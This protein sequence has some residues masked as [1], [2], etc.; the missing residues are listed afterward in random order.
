MI[1]GTRN[2]GSKTI[3]A[4]DVGTNSIHM[5]I[6]AVN[7]HSTLHVLERNKEVVRLGSS[8]TDM[9]QLSAEA[10]DRGVAALQRFAVE[11]GSHKALIKAVATSA[12]REA[13]NR[14]VFLDRV[15]KTSGIDVEVVSGVEEGRLIYVGVLHSLPVISRQTLVIDIGGGSTETVIGSQGD[16]V[17]VHSVKLGHIR[18]T[19]RF[20]PD[21]IATPETIEACRNAVRNEWTPTFQ[22]L[23][24]AGFN[25][26]VGT[27]GTIKALVGMT[28]AR[29]GKHVPESLN[30]VR[31]SRDDMMTTIN[32]VISASADST[33]ALLP[34]LDPKR[35]D[36][37]LA[38][39]LILEQAFVGLNIADLVVSRFAL[40]EGLAFDTAQK[41]HDIQQYHHL[42]SLR[43]QSIMHL[44]ELYQVRLDHA[45]HVKILALQIFDALQNVHNLTDRERELLEAASLLHDV[46]YHI[47]AEQHHKHSEYII[48]NSDLSGFTND[49]ADLIAAIARY[50]RKSHPKKKHPNYNR[51]PAS[52]KRIVR[53]L[54]SI[55][56]I[57]EG[58]DRRQ[59]AIVRNVRAVVTVSTIEL[60]LE[61][62]EKSD[63]EVWSAERRKGL[64]E[65]VFKREVLL[66]PC[67]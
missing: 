47:S 2:S 64:M 51:L 55:L 3:A 59:L 45:E 40:C 6:A 39:A 4:I 20:F 10:M 62:S 54:A 14:D 32:N 53:I 60:S 12:V 22:D 48:A 50:H 63:I 29:Q 44:C 52:S 30:G 61:C 37:I 27:S 36:V 5:V 25:E 42:S 34:G 18:L 57:A 15:L 26:V 33:V 58:L 38:G 7:T 67:G 28:L 1:S 66:V 56:R 16:V 17:A 19:K 13:N 23:M 24:R 11:A 43:Y 31:V 49:E 46:G 9:K 41:M 21:G 65:E 35:A 8:A